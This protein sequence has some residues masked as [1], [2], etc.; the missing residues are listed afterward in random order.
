MTA[1]RPSRPRPWRG[2]A[3]SRSGMSPR[4]GRAQ[5]AAAFLKLAEIGER[6]DRI[7]AVPVRAGLADQA[8][9]LALRACDFREL[10]HGAGMIMRIEIDEAPA[11]ADFAAHHR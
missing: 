2:R 11:L 6:A 10:D 3:A 1:R 5:G 7:F 9:H 4:S 8:E